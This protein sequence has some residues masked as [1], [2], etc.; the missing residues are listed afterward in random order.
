MP[1]RQS[2]AAEKALR[3]ELDSWERWR[4]TLVA[5]QGG[6]KRGRAKSESGITKKCKNGRAGTGVMKLKTCNIVEVKD[7]K[8]IDL[9]GQ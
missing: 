7:W 6:C 2:S 8:V 5:N 1:G 3:R 4:A 9:P